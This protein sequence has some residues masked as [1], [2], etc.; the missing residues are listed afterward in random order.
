MRVSRH[1]EYTH[2][3]MK[4]FRPLHANLFVFVFNIFSSCCFIT[5]SQSLLSLKSSNKYKVRLTSISPLT[6]LLILVLGRS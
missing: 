6:Y 5:I 3:K 4:E 2:D 1:F